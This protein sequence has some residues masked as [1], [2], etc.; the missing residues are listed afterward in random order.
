MPYVK[1]PG[2]SPHLTFGVRCCPRTHN[3]SRSVTGLIVSALTNEV[4]KAACPGS[5]LLRDWK[6]S[7]S[8][9]TLCWVNNLH[10]RDL[11]A[12]PGSSGWVAPL[13]QESQY[14][15]VLKGLHFCQNRL[16]STRH[17]T[18]RDGHLKRAESISRGPA[19]HWRL[20]NHRFENTDPHKEEGWALESE[21][22]ANA[23]LTQVTTPRGMPTQP[24]RRT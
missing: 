4:G 3:S 13:S 23:A 2:R 19:E 7:E 22:L 10:R 6:W 9:V 21:P 8:S 5:G 1:G 11:M 15:T 17:I 20:W 18:P 24:P 14:L 16:F 12:G